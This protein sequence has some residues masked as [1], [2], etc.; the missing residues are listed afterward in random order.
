M[1]GHPTD[2]GWLLMAGHPRH[3][4][5]PEAPFPS[6]APEAKE[7]LRQNGVLAGRAHSPC[8]ACLGPL[9]IGAFFSKV[10]KCRPDRP[11]QDCPHL[12]GTALVS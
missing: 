2:R 3:E 9:N 1:A 11:W 8:V 6:F 4:T 7:V 12:A 10:L 5:P